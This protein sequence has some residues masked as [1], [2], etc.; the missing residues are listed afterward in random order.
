MGVQVLASALRGLGRRGDVSPAGVS[1][2]LPEAPFRVT[3]PAR[4]ELTPEQLRS[5]EEEGFCVCRGWFTEAE[6]ALLG[7]AIETDPEL[8]A[9][10]ITVPDTQGL[11]TRLALWM[12]LGDNTCSMF[13]RSATLVRA[14]TVLMGGSEPYH[15]HS[16]VLL[17][18]PGVGGAWEWHQ[19]GT[20]RSQSLLPAPAELALT[21]SCV[22]SG[23]R[24]LLQR[25]FAAA[26]EGDERRHS[27]G[28][29]HIAQ[30]LHALHQALSHA[31]T[32]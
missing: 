22:S 17:K 31:R 7:T 28:L 25:G 3:T 19:V 18:E 21:Y 10:E 12:Q 29:Q 11:D 30:R 14:A 20:L 5:Y 23:L 27:R 24:I 8:S 6:I 9:Q 13:A 15:S 32:R 2:P 16:K 4:H 26:G 1:G